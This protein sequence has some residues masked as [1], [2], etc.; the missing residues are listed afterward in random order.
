MTDAPSDR[1]RLCCESQSDSRRKER[2]QAHWHRLSL[3]ARASSSELGYLQQRACHRRCVGAASRGHAPASMTFFQLSASSFPTPDFSTT[4]DFST[5]G[6]GGRGGGRG[7]LEGRRPSD[8]LDC[9]PAAR[10]PLRRVPAARMTPSHCPSCTLDACAHVCVHVCGPYA[11][12]RTHAQAQTAHAHTRMQHHRWHSAVR[13]ASPHAGS[14]TAQGIRACA[15]AC[16]CTPMHACKRAHPPAPWP[17][18]G[19]GW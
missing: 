2:P 11:C 4:G 12:A 6:F 16:T 19:P 17:P 8:A 3:W 18:S 7:E 13:Q 9:A 1:R 5:W 15:G 14:R 10:L